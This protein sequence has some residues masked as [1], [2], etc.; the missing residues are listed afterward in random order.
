MEED[1]KS[2]ERSDLSL[3]ERGVQ[4]YQRSPVLRMIVKL[5][6]P[7]A[8]AEAGVL[9]VYEYFRN[10]R[11]HVF[12]D[13]FLRLNL[14]VSEEQARERDFVDAFT[15]TAKRVLNTSQDEKIRLFAHAFGNFVKGGAFDSVDAFE[16]VLSV[17]D[18][19]SIREFQLL[20][21]LRRHEEMNERIVGENRLH[22]AN[23]FWQQFTKDA[24][25]ELNIP[26]QELPGMLER[27]NRTGLYTTII[28]AYLDYV[29]DRGHLTPIFDRFLMVLDQQSAKR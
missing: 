1:S 14:Q 15:A 21:L 17:L 8:V 7:L 16:E 5:Y 12:G 22:R 10:R 18:D 3:L 28:G 4:A 11:M 2:L 23:R 13:E 20:L 19:M 25:N 9:G 6:P 29:G 26:P 27:L 24:E